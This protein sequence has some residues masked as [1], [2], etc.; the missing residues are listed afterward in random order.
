[1]QFTPSLLA[2]R[3]FDNAYIRQTT[4][5]TSN[6]QQKEQTEK[7]S[8][9]KGIFQ[10]LFPCLS[11]NSVIVLKQKAVSKSQ[12]TFLSFSNCLTL[13]NAKTKKVETLARESQNEVYSNLQKGLATLNIFWEKWGERYEAPARV[14]TFDQLKPVCD[15]F[16]RGEKKKIFSSE[17]KKAFILV[18]ERVGYMVFRQLRL[19]K[20]G[21]KE[22]CTGI[23][24]QTGKLRAISIYEALEDDK[25]A[26]FLP[27]D[28]Y[29]IL[30]ENA[31]KNNCGGILPLIDMCYLTFDKT[32]E[33]TQ[34][35]VMELC[36]DGDLSDHIGRFTSEQKQKI[37]GD[38]FQGIQ[39]LHQCGL[40]HRDIKLENILLSIQGDEVIAHIGDNDLTDKKDKPLVKLASYVLFPPEIILGRKK[41][42]SFNEKSEVWMWGFA[43]YA[44]CAGEIPKIMQ[45]LI[46]DHH[47]FESFD[48]FEVLLP[49]KKPGANQAPLKVVEL[50]SKMLSL[51]EEER[52]TMAEARQIY[53]SIPANGFDLPKEFI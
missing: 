32:P 36:P 39:T 43:L 50:L 9:T 37:A 2:T 6:P 22:V 12:G 23:S 3:A 4:I 34:F 14:P 28:I 18:I 41:M 10:S 21:K 1:M 49:W 30:R 51:Q 16:I 42:A 17:N 31:P 40:L 46:E 11:G 38:V 48:D 7:T 15:Q 52:C 24:M 53:D 20:G 47:K 5:Y 27:Y 35:I 25:N 44:L 19:G 29:H 45:E 33:K 26:C 8:V 13:P